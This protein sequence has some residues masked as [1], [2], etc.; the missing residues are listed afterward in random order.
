MRLMATQDVPA[1]WGRRRLLAMLVGVVAFAALLVAG[2][3]LVVGQLVTSST[4]VRSERAPR[5]DYPIRADGTRG[6]EYRDFVAAEPM[7]V[8]DR[9]DMQPGEPALRQLDPLV[10]GSPTGIGPASVPSGFEHTREGAVAQLAAI[11][12]SALEPMS[13]RE[14]WSVHAAWAAPG[15]SFERW[16]LT[17]SIQAFHA[18]AGT[19]DGDGAVALTASPVGAQIKGTDGPDWVLACVQLDIT[20]TVVEQTRFG[21]GHC[22]RM[23]W[24]GSRWIVGAGSP[25]AQAPSTWPGSQRSVDAGW[26]PWV[27]TDV[28]E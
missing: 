13:I 5:S 25:P 14:A 6:A 8:S 26:R 17:Q 2:L 23:Q 28:S 12:I 16:E 20:V 9:Q 24:D 22:D 19:T 11:S 10:A 4:A 21:F 27:E 7:L 18:E 3:V 1:E 15:A